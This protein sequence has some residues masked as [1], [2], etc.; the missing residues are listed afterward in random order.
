MAALPVPQMY[1]IAMITEPSFEDILEFLREN[2]FPFEPCAK[3]LD[4]CPHGYR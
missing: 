2:F 3:A 4:L 1:K